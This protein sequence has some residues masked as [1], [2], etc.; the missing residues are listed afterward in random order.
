M[1]QPAHSHYKNFDPD[2][3]AERLVP[4]LE[5]LRSLG[6]VDHKIYNQIV[7][8][9]PRLEGGAY[10]KSEVIRAFRRFAPRFGWEDGNSF[11]ARLRMKPVRTLSGVAPVTVLTKPFPCPGRCIFCP[12][13]VRMPKS[14]L[15]REPGAQRAAQH[16]FDPYGQTLGRLLTYHH[17]GHLVDKVELIIL[18]GTWSSYPEPYQIWFVKRCFDAMN[19]FRAELAEELPHDVRGDLDFEELSEEVEGGGEKTYNE[20]VQK[21]LRERL[22]GR[23]TDDV[24]RARWSELEGAHAVNE[25]AEARCVGLVLETR[26]DHLD[27][28]EVERLRRLGATKVQVGIQSLDDEVLRLNG[29]GHD[30]ES[31]RRALVMLRSA[32]F[33]LHIHWMPNLLGADPSSDA[34]DF[35]QLFSDAAIR[36]DELKIYP[37][38]LIETAELM[39]HFRSGAWRPY[40]NEELA[41]LLEGCLLE[42]PEYCRVTRVIRDIPG[43]EIV[44]GNKTTNFRQVVEERL[45]RRGLRSRDIRAREIRTGRIDPQELELV[46]LEYDTP[47]SQETFLQVVTGDDRL[48]GFCRLSVPKEPPVLDELRQCAMIREVHVYGSVSAI[49]DDPDDA[50]GGRSQHRGLGRRLVEEAA[51]RAAAAGFAKLAVI[52]AIG[53]R[54]YYR[55]LGFCDGELYQI[56]PI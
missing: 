14:Y 12:S 4:M 42:V 48:A 35:L 2:Q 56:R 36:P 13:D 33:K 21:F 27:A 17:N 34:R 50:L 3:H 45:E 20:V 29:R 30:V 1:P 49:G 10:S 39:V 16:R 24:E 52:S 23:L 32:G 5:E 51:R 28:A 19:D 38:S 53:T 44:E 8:R 11:I 15:S 7:R 40:G 26:P 47:G 43:D 54:E 25:H 22:A 31:S 6:A 46:A 41:E 9:Y 55:K 18:G 37:C